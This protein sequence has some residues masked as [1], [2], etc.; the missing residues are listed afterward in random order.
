MAASAKLNSER[1]L[2]RELRVFLKFLDQIRWVPQ[3]L[4][5]YRQ[6]FGAGA[7]GVCG[8]AREN[9]EAE[10]RGR[11]YLLRKWKHHPDFA[12]FK[13]LVKRADDLPAMRA[14]A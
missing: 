11:R 6:A 9:V 13:S 12:G 14:K 3:I 8:E 7:D 1:R 5:E 4:V 2:R 10:I